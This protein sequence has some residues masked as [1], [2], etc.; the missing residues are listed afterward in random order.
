MSGIHDRIVGQHE[1]F[2]LDPRHQLRLA[3]SREIGPPN[4][5]GEQHIASQD[6]QRCARR[7]VHH[8]PRTVSGNLPDQKLHPQ[9]RE[10]FA[11]FE[12]TGRRRT[13]QWQTELTTQVQRR[14]GQHRGVPP[15][16]QDRQLGP[17]LPQV[18]N[19]GDMVHM[20]MCQQDGDRRGPQILDRPHNRLRPKSRVDNQAVATGPAMHNQRVLSEWLS[21]HHFDLQ[22]G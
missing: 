5:P 9:K 20:P 2:L 19:P 11:L 6:P 7:N 12:Q 22:E 13:G 3:A 16:N 10:P 1:Q 8:V 4:A 18:V 17:A 14:V 15:T 21:H